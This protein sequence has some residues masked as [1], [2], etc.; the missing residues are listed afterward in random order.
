MNTIVSN[1][2]ARTIERKIRDSIQAGSLDLAEAAIEQLREVDPKSPAVS[3][4]GALL[5]ISRGQVHEAL[6]LL[7]TGDHPHA[8]ALCLYLMGDPSWEGLA[9]AYQHDNDVNVREAMRSLLV[10]ESSD[11][12]TRIHT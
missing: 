10:H 9:L 7:N 4:G 6:R 11:R 2:F 12:N 8:R 5:L 3:L 1:E